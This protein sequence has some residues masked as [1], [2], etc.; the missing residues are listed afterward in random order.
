MMA[1]YWEEVSNDSWAT[2]IL[3]L[4]LIWGLSNV[5]LLISDNEE[6]KDDTIMDANIDNPGK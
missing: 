2:N 6:V 5:I 3:G 1:I 4:I